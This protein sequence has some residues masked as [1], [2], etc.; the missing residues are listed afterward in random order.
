MGRKQNTNYI[1]SKFTLQPHANKEHLSLP[2]DLK[3]N[4]L[5]PG[6]VRFQNFNVTEFKNELPVEEG[7]YARVQ[8]RRVEMP[9]QNGSAPLENGS[10]HTHAPSLETGTLPFIS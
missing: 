3:E 9:L 8:K 10:S 4:G 6:G 7:L 2:T 5:P 1:Y